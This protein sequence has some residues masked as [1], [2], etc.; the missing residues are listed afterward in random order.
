M[1][2]EASPDHYAAALPG[3]LAMVMAG[4]GETLAF[5]GLVA[6]SRQVAHLLRR[7]GIGPGETVAIL[8]ENHPRFLEI[9]W[10]AQRA[11]LRYTAIS[12]RLTAGEVA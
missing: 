8:V 9:A 6:R 11:G 4:S 2:L 7:R 10:G 3:K 5:A 1:A 12:T